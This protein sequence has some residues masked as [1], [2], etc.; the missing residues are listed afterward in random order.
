MPANGSVSVLRQTLYCFV[1][2]GDMY[3]AYHVKKLRWYLLLI[4]GVGIVTSIALNAIYPILGM[5]DEEFS[6]KDL[7]TD[8]THVF[9]EYDSADAVF[10]I[11]I[12]MAVTYAVAVYLIR[13][14]SKQWNRN[15]DQT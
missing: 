15:F 10:G 13:R 5:S 6:L 14:W 7:E 4:F 2:I 12:Q 11:L 3:A 9:P 8:M 1:P